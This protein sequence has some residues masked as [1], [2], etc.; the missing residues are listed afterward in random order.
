M[1]LF[2]T[3]IQQSIRQVVIEEELFLW[4]DLLHLCCRTDIT[5]LCVCNSGTKLIC[6]L[7][8]AIHVDKR[9][10][11]KTF[12]YGGS[13]GGIRGGIEDPYTAGQ[14]PCCTMLRSWMLL[15]CLQQFICSCHH[16]Y[17][18]FCAIYIFEVSVKNSSSIKVQR[19][20]HQM[21]QK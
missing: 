8:V 1:L 16:R 13:L 4:Q 19:H 5:L 3:A 15:H 12:M 14:M 21:H 7:T 9:N 17:N 10:V 11:K 6:F 18:I 20:F 2:R